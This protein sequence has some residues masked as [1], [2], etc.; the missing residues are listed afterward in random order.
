MGRKSTCDKQTFE[1]IGKKKHIIFNLPMWTKR[2]FIFNL[3]V[4]LL[5]TAMS[6]YRPEDGSCLIWG[7]DYQPVSWPY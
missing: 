4:T 1:A 5:N 2:D 7:S 6:L 3:L